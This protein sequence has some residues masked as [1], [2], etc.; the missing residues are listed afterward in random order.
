MRPKTELQIHLNRLDDNYEQL[1]KIAPHN[2]IIFMVKANG[3]GHGILEIV[4]F[5]Y[6]ELGIKNFGVASVGEAKLIRQMLPKI[7]VKLYVFSD[8]DLLGSKELY[9]EYNIT[10]VI[11]Y[12]D[13]LKEFLES[14]DFKHTPL[15]LKFNTGMNRLGIEY[16]ELQKV[17]ELL[18][19]H[20]R[21]SIDHLM[22]HFANSYLPLKK[23]DKTHRQFDLFKKIKQEL[24]GAGLSVLEDSVAN[25]GAVEQ[26]FG[27][28]CSHI[29]PGLML[30]GAKSHPKS[31]WQGK[32][33]SDFKT[34]VL[35]SVLFKKGMPIGYGS[36]PCHEDG[37]VLYLP[38]GYGDGVFTYY[39]GKKINLY[40]RQAKIL[41]RVN[42]DITSIFFEKPPR[43]FKRNDDFYL[44]GQGASEASELAYQLKTTAYQLFTGIS[45]RVPRRYLK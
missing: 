10:P 8:L 6:Y 18:K 15:V 9:T 5:A 31:S 22:T 12:I 17:I 43:D 39:S 34:V 19:K 45:H 1:K 32:C 11:S 28:E 29:R 26:Q 41:G 44:W 23:E 14:S 36:Q 24:K 25:S 20:A 33:I 16:D 35:K 4:S 40:Q 7:L 42:M 21:L 38:V 30:Y 27:L 3:Y 37:T 13:E 2:E